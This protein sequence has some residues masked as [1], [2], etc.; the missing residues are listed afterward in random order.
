MYNVK[1]LTSPL[2]KGQK[3]EKQD[4]REIEISE[5][6]DNRGMKPD[7]YFGISIATIKSKK[8]TEDFFLPTNLAREIA[9]AMIKQADL[10]DKNFKPKKKPVVKKVVKKKL[11]LKLAR[12]SK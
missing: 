11:S 7:V 1:L 8:I 9:K 2:S 12:K 6:V 5:S 3:W 4:T 10:I